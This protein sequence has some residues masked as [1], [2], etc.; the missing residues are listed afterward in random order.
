MKTSFVLASCLILMSV[1]VII[2]VTS[3]QAENT[4]RKVINKVVPEYPRLARNMSLRGTVRLEVR[5]NESG[6]VKSVDIKGGSP[7]LVQ[8]AE[9]AVR[10]WKWEKAEH[11][12]TESVEIDFNP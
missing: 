2:P 9:Q 1:G 11:E 8:S 7:I 5:V 3:A 4:N 10:A 12:T 6:N